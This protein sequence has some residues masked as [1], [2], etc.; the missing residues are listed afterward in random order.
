MNDMSATALVVPA[1]ACLDR[2]I[3]RNRSTLPPRQPVPRSVELENLPDNQV[4]SE[5]FDDWM[6]LEIALKC[7]GR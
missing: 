6:V 3:E 4:R 5:Y 7:R 1:C 2:L